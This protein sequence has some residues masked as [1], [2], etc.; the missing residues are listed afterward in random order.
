MNS[1][2]SL[3]QRASYPNMYIGDFIGMNDKIN[4]ED[5]AHNKLTP[6]IMK[7]P[8]YLSKINTAFHSLTEGLMNKKN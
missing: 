7:S 8:I 5:D 6:I 2:T 1:N 3:L 4:V